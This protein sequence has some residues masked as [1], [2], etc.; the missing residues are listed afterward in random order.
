MW[1]IR[2]KPIL[3]DVQ[4]GHKKTNPQL[5]RVKLTC[6]DLLWPFWTS[7]STFTLPNHPQTKEIAAECSFRFNNNKKNIYCQ[8]SPVFEWSLESRLRRSQTAK[9]VCRGLGGL[10]GISNVDTDD[11]K[12]T[13]I[14]WVIGER[15]QCAYEEEI[16]YVFIWLRTWHDLST[17]HMG[18]SNSLAGVQGLL[19]NTTRL[20]RKW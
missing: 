15:C 20:Y 1:N 5:R 11:H 8:I 16:H 12:A 10:N 2:K 9:V 13:D 18:C 3:L 14:G 4:R 19:H 6:T 17:D 7:S